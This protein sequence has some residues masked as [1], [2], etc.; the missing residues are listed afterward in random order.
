MLKQ[1]QSVNRAFP[2][3]VAPTIVQWAIRASDGGVDIAPANKELELPRTPDGLYIVGIFIGADLK[4]DTYRS[5]RYMSDGSISIAAKDGTQDRA[6]LKKNLPLILKKPYWTMYKTGCT[7]SG[8]EVHSIMWI[9]VKCNECSQ[10]KSVLEMSQNSTE[11]LST[12][13]DCADNG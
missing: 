4:S 13:K 1:Q 8:L 5:R 11:W 12:C 6:E 2:V 9:G 3:L 7:A 10:I